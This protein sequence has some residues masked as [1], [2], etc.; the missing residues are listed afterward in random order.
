MSDEQTETCEHKRVRFTGRGVLLNVQRFECLDCGAII[1][2]DEEPVD[3]ARVRRVH[4]AYPGKHGLARA[5][6][7]LGIDETED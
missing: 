1:V 2:K 3:V 7:L 6:A 4:D 5:K